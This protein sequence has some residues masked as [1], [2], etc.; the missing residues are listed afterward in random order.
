MTA[1]QIR[2]VIFAETQPGMTPQQI[3]DFVEARFAGVHLDAV[4][5]G[6][7]LALNELRRQA[8]QQLGES[9]ALERFKRQRRLRAIQD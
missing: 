9:D 4:E 7:R 5:S 3:A 2:D 8:E 1:E 6:I